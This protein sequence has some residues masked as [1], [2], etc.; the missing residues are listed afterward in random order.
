M[1]S[2]GKEQCSIEMWSV[3]I[4][5]QVWEKERWYVSSSVKWESY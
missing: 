3:G 2:F 5:K 4:Y 1:K